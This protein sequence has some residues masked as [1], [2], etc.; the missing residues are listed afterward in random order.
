MS[1]VNQRGHLFDTRGATLTKKK[2]MVVMGLFYQ[3]KGIRV[4]R[5]RLANHLQIIFIYLTSHLSST[6]PNKPRFWTSSNLLIQHKRPP[7]CTNYFPKL[8]KEM[9][10]ISIFH[11]WPSLFQFY[12]VI[13][14]LKWS[15]AGLKKFRVECKSKHQGLEPVVQMNKIKKLCSSYL[16]HSSMRNSSRRLSF[17]YS[18][19]RQKTTSLRS[20]TSDLNYKQ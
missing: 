2:T 12:Q 16:K 18:W 9:P 4:R 14:K 10:T 3:V 6:L 8:H 17:Y 19:S 13:M 11:N 7:I 5:K 1:R 20:R 15:P